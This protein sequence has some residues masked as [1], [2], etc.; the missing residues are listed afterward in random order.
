MKY[1]FKKIERRKKLCAAL[2]TA[3][4]LLVGGFWYA[5]PRQTAQMMVGEADVE[6]VMQNITADSRASRTISW[7]SAEPGAGANLVEYR[8]EGETQSLKKTA[9]NKEIQVG[10]KTVYLHFAT[11]DRLA[12]GTKYQYRVGGENAWSEWLAFDTDGGGPFKALIFPDSQC[13]DYAVWEA[14]AQTAWQRNPDAR[15]FINMGDLVDNGEDL[16]QW[17]RWLSG[18][19][20]MIERIPAAPIVGNHEAYSLRWKFAPP[21]LYLDLFTLPENGPP[22]LAEQ[23]YSYDYGDVHFAVVDTQEEELAE[24]QPEIL[25]AQADWLAKDLSASAKKWKIV[26]MHRGLFSY[27]DVANPNRLG[28]IFMPILDRAKVDVVFTAHIHS[29]GRTVPLRG[30]IPAGKR[31]TIYISTGRSGDKVWE[32]SLRKPVETVFDSA[33]DQPNYLTLEE[34][35]GLLRIQSVKQNGNLIDELNLIK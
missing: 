18:A 19:A 23:C 7:Q 26:L 14:M 13:A 24:F 25:S 22:S 16:S 2:L 20:G 8:V 31:G 35:N 10:G 32:G 33:L 5:P 12:P 15:F 21:S 6:Y 34:R 17:K 3:V 30:A 1:L 9:S 27:P 11:L 4:C 28:E 29:Y